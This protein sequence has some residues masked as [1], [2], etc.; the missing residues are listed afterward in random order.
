MPPQGYEPRTV[1]PVASNRV[2]V[3]VVVASVVVVAVVV[4]VIFVVT[5]RAR[6]GPQETFI[7]SNSVHTGTGVHRA[8]FQWVHGDSFSGAKAAKV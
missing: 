1:Q 6:Y 2:V 3:V 4:V 5:G 7:F 8:S